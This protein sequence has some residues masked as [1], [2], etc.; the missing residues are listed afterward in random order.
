MIEINYPD[1]RKMISPKKKDDQVDHRRTSNKTEAE[2]IRESFI[3]SNMGMQFENDVSKSCDFYREKGMADIYK[4]P[5]PIKVVKMS[6]TKKGMIEEAYF[7]EKSTTD[8]VG[9]YR[10]KYIDFESEKSFLSK[11]SESAPVALFV[12]NRLEHPKKVIESLLKNPEAKDTDLYVFS[13]GG[14]YLDDIPVIKDL[15]HFL[16]TVRGFNSVKVIERK[17]NYGLA[18]NLIDGISAVLEEHE[19]CIVLEDDIVVAPNFLAF[20]NQALNTYKNNKQI[21]TIQSTTGN[22]KL[23]GDCC[24]RKHPNCWGWAIWKDR[25]SLYERNVAQAFVDINADNMNLRTQINNNN[26][27]N[28]CWQI[29]ANLKSERNTWG[30]YLNYISFKY[31]FLN[32]YPKY[33]LIKNIGQD[34]TGVH[35]CVCQTDDIVSWQKNVFD[36]PNMPEIDFVNYKPVREIEQYNN[37]IVQNNMD[38]F[39]LKASAGK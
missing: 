21:F 27:V 17:T 24:C 2:R 39:L 30:V 20:M 18:I 31:D 38:K 16:K 12:Y 15:R 9:I 10:G 4:R 36:L 26:S 37:Q 23:P 3:K 11:K 7:Q 35:G 34:G 6:K 13:D 33:Q 32:V 22:S 5:T 29:D 28:I 25:W 14:K 8:Y 19:N 1:G